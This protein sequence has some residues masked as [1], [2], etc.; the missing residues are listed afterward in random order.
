MG[1]RTESS[2]LFLGPGRHFGRRC[3]AQLLHIT[4]SALDR[5]QPDN[6]PGRKR[7]SA[8]DTT[9]RRSLGGSHRLHRV[10]PH[11]HPQ[12]RHPTP[13]ALQQHRR[14]YRQKK[15]ASSTN[16]TNLNCY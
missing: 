12:C 2:E 1:T 6:G 3:E 14:S 16:Q 10:L 7:P 9:L 11:A 4:G 15:R 13:F 8:A 5:S